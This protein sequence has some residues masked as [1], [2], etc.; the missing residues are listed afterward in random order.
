MVRIWR[1]C[2]KRILSF[3]R[4][5]VNKTFTK[6]QCFFFFL[7][8]WFSGGSVACLVFIVYNITV[9]EHGE[10]YLFMRPRHLGKKYRKGTAE[11]VTL[12]SIGMVIEECIAYIEENA[13]W[14]G[15]VGLAVLILLFLLGALANAHRSRKQVR[16]LRAIDRKMANVLEE[17]Q[18]A[19]AAREAI[20]QGVAALQ[21]E[22][23]KAAAPTYADTVDTFFAETDIESVADAAETVEEPAVEEAIP[24]EQPAEE[25]IPEEAPAEEPAP[26]MPA[27]NTEEQPAE[28][29]LESLREALLDAR[30]SEPVMAAPEESAA[31][32]DGP[33][34]RGR[35]G[36][37]YTREE[38]EHQIRK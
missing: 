8:G 3:Y 19:A 37:L 32:P 13:V 34:A 10:V 26:E 20:A 5:G 14:L 16:L 2:A 7:R 21:D 23:E 1:C 25:A 12:E 33:V 31:A 24:E 11:N 22:P 30:D 36:R 4:G 27:E 17:Q 18:T 6:K 15:I 38:L 9:Y 35:S 28:I 29:S